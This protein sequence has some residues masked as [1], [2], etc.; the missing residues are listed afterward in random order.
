MIPVTI[1]DHADH[2]LWP[3]AREWQQQAPFHLRMDGDVCTTCGCLLGNTP[4][5]IPRVVSALLVGQENV[6][7][8]YLYARDAER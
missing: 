7:T 4:T 8:R 3:I 6:T 2:A 5:F 1:K